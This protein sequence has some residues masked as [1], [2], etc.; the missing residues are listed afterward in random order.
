[1]L[2]IFLKFIDLTMR[3]N[4]KR[5]ASGSF[6]RTNFLLPTKITTCYQK[7]ISA[8][9]SS[10]TW[11]T[12][13][14]SSLCAPVAGRPS[15]FPLRMTFLVHTYRGWK[16]KATNRALG[17]DRGCILSQQFGQTI[18]AITRHR[19]PTHSNTKHNVRGRRIFKSP[20]I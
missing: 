7:G 14:S 9:E 20:R 18:V 2:Y 5:K 3:C 1:M 17:D 8:V 16:E 6:E 19:D 10:V 13:D 11:D 15:P 4:R 12:Q